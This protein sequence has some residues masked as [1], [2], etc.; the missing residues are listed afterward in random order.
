MKILVNRFVGNLTHIFVL[1][2]GSLVWKS[3]F[4]LETSLRYVV[5]V[6]YEL[7][8][9]FVSFFYFLDSA[10]T[11]LLFDLDS[12]M[13][14]LFKLETCLPGYCQMIE[15][16]N[17]FSEWVLVSVQKTATLI[18]KCFVINCGPF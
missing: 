15:L 6:L 12:T 3:K 10:D 1:L 4:D 18:C 11:Q 8:S 5:L 13:K 9:P 2:L 17:A 7:F 14:A 16:L